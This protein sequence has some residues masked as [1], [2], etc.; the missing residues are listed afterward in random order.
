MQVCKYAG[1]QVCKHISMQVYRYASM[2]L[3]MYLHCTIYK[4]YYMSIP[5]TMGVYETFASICHKQMKCTG[6]WPPQLN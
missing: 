2:Q 3:S 1:M 4:Q 6:H 5:P